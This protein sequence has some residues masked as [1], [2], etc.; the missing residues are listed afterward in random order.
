MSGF[1]NSLFQC[2][3][4]GNIT[5]MTNDNYLNGV[6]GSIMEGFSTNIDSCITNSITSNISNDIIE[7]QFNKDIYNVGN[8]NEHLTGE[9]IYFSFSTKYIGN[10][11]DKENLLVRTLDYLDY[12]INGIPYSGIINK[13]KKIMKTNI[14][15]SM[16]SITIYGNR[17]PIKVNIYSLS[18]RKI[19]K[20]QMNNEKYIFDNPLKRGIYFIII[21][22]SNGFKSYKD[23]VLE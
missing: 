4:S 18:G 6:V 22:D 15:L 2:S 9:D 20:F 13:D 10:S 21:Q 12:T 1:L 5:N 23:I 3:Y 11:A 19:L 17:K 14:R 8:T 16:N 7:I